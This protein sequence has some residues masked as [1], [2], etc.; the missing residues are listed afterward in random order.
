MQDLAPDRRDYW[1]AVMAQRRAAEEWAGR[2]EAA[3]WS[4]PR[5]ARSLPTTAGSSRRL[6]SAT[7]L[8]LTARTA[9]G[10]EHGTE[11]PRG[12]RRACQAF[13]EGLVRLGG[14]ANAPCASISDADDVVLGRDYW[15]GVQVPTLR[16][17]SVITISPWLD[18]NW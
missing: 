8:L 2:G 10:A 14:R 9:Q 1:R 17:L 16:P 4:R 18:F 11:R 7:D 12:R 5:C 3:G 6:L 15:P 13:V